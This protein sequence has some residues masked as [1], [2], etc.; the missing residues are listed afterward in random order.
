M[1]VVS[2]PIYT[3]LMHINLV[4]FSLC[5]FEQEMWPLLAQ[6]VQQTSIVHEGHDQ[7]GG[8]ASVYANTNQV[9]HIQMVKIFHLD[10][11]LQHF[12]NSGV[13]IVTCQDTL[14]R[15]I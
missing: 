3:P 10:A 5:V 12:T 14:M 11:L 13:I 7:I 8:G 1:Y 9:E 2:T 6:V 4:W 15:V